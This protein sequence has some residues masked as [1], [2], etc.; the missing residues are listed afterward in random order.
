MKKLY[1][2]FLIMLCMAGAVALSSC[3][4][5]DSSS[6]GDP[7]M[8]ESGNALICNGVVREI[9]SAVYTVETPGNGEKADVP[10]AAPV[11]T[12][13]F[14]PTAGLVDADGM[15]IA[16][17]AVKI[18]VK[19]PSGAVD[20]TAAGN[21]I[22]YGE[23]DVN[24]SNVGEAS[25]AVL[26]VEFLSARVARISA[27]I[28]TGGKT[29]TVAYY[30]PCKNSDASEEGD[31]ADKVVLDKVPLSWYL[32][33]VKGVES[34]NYYMAFTDAEYTVAKGQV[35]LK[36]A[37]YLFVAD[38]YAVP[39]ED[40]YT[41]PEG[42]YMASQLNEDHT[43]T[44]QYT[45]VQYI[46]AEG[47]KTQLS[48]VPGEPLK[49][50]R[51]GD[52]WS[53]SLRF[54]DKDGTEKSIVYEGSLKIVDQPEGGGF[55]LPQIGHDVEVVGTKAAAIYSGNMLKAGTGMMQITIYDE[56][57]D[58]E[59]GKGGLGATLIVFHDLFGNPKDAAIKPCE[60]TPSTSFLHSTWMP[61]VEIPVS[62]MVFPFG[63]SVH[64]DDGTNY[65]K[66]SY[67]KEGTI[68]IED[69]GTSEGVDGKTEPQ[70]KIEFNLTS[71]DGFNIKGSYTGVIP[72]TDQSN[73]KSDDDGTSTLER[74]Y[75]MDLS[76]ITKAHLYTSDRIYIQGLGYKQVSSYS[77][78]LQFINIGKAT[79][80]S[81]R[82]PGGDI[83][84][85]ELVT[86]PGKENVITPGTYEVTEQRWPAYI[87]PGV[88]MRGI[89]LAGD[90]HGSRWMHQY[91]KDV[92]GQ[93]YEYM[94]G[95]ALFYGG[96]VTI[97]KVEGEGK[98]NWYRFE[99][100][101]TCVRKHHVR[102][103]WEGPVESQ[104]AG[105]AAAEKDHLEPPRL[106]RRLPAP[107]VPMS[108]LAEKLPDVMFRKAGMTE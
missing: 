50:T 63:T 39:G 85:M 93:T 46:D 43:F 15:L 25:K 24:S 28:E 73:D 105:G 89:M 16:D 10:E 76:K 82:E 83:V 55:Y 47:N 75:D 97:T 35:T 30:G 17:D 29:L 72:I 7:D 56:T 13:Y 1:P 22:V 61:A 21:G 11:Y 49:V 53:I 88:M 57:Y 58:Q 40:A 38:L 26:S 100:D 92:D 3:S 107:K 79:D 101:A 37:G 32:G 23:I 8:P 14:S 5:D 62:G 42:E 52:V 18:T 87:K 108:R 12:I 45:G 31:D 95:H 51:E 27:E 20:L 80:F 41:L 54:K 106:L 96:K 99:F 65:R 9:K 44:S 90:L 84:R 78:G 81:D 34:H 70:Y 68:K 59:E 48:L 94:D 102:G 67:G 71:K 86:E 66:F 19:Q 77:C 69:A 64:M 74:D 60:Y 98:D 6:S 104:T 103:T 36:E 33:P 4:D 91:P 2:F